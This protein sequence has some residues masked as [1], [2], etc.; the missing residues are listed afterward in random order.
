[1]PNDQ[2]EESWTQP[3]VSGSR[4]HL[5]EQDHLMCSQL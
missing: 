2:E 1:M 3:V 5:H 4:R